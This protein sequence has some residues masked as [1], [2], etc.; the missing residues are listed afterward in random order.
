MFGNVLMGDYGT[1]SSVYY[2]SPSLSDMA[3]FIASRVYIDGFD[4][5]SLG[6][7]FTRGLIF[8]PH[9]FPFNESVLSLSLF[10]RHI[11]SP[12]NVTPQDRV[13]IQA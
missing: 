8:E 4:N 7:G 13:T 2:V 3:Y 5:H 10:Q 6:K 9:F 12:P 1:T 11:S